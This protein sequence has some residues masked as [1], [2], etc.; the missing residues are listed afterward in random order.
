M[1]E[2]GTVL[3]ERN[4]E[5]SNPE[6]LLHTLTKKN[7]GKAPNNKADCKLSSGE[8]KHSLRLHLKVQFSGGVRPGIWKQILP[9]PY[10]G[11]GQ[12]RARHFRAGREGKDSAKRGYLTFRE[13]K[14][15][16]SMLRVWGDEMAWGMRARLDLLRKL[17]W[18]DG[19]RR[20]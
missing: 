6:I 7:R 20:R 1:A 8:L 15:K 12:A 13:L 18:D 4:V 5:T 17:R 10:R 2:V 14:L 3:T 19:I 9:C 16:E 11:G